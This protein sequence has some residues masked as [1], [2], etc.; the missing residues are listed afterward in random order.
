MRLSTNLVAEEVEQFLNVQMI[1]KYRFPREENFLVFSSTL[2]IS[3]LPHI[4]ENVLVSTT[5]TRLWWCDCARSSKVLLKPCAIYV[6]GM[7]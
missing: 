2:R 6:L 5:C 1:L 3:L 7:P 4:T